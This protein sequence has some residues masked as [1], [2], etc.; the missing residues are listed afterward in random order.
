MPLP[1]TRAPHAPPPADRLSRRRHFLAATCLLVSGCLDAGSVALLNPN[2][3]PGAASPTTR[4]SAIPGNNG[5][6]QATPSSPLVVLHSRTTLR[7]DEFRDVDSFVS[8]IGLGPD[9]DLLWEF[10]PPNLIGVKREAGRADVIYGYQP[11][12]T[13]VTVRLRRD[14]TIQAQ[15]TIEVSD[16]HTTG[17]LVEPVDTGIHIGDVLNYRAVLPGTK[18]LYA[19]R[20]RWH[21]N[22][23]DVIAIDSDTGR[24]TALKPGSAIITSTSDDTRQN[25]NKRYMGV[26]DPKVVAP[27]P[28]PVATVAPPGPTRVM[29]GRW[30]IVSTIPASHLGSNA[31]PALDM[32]FGDPM[33]GYVVGGGGTVTRTADGGLTWQ[34]VPL[35][36]GNDDDPATAIAA[37]A[38]VSAQTG[39]VSTYGGAVWRTLDGGAHWLKS[40]VSAGKVLR[41]L[42]AK[43]SNVL[44]GGDTTVCSRSAD[45]GVT[46]Q[47]TPN[48]LSRGTYRVSMPG[49]DAW[50]VGPNGVA[51][52]TPGQGWSGAS[53]PHSLQIANPLAT[54]LT[55]VLPCIADFVSAETGFVGTMYD[56]YR[57]TDGAATWRSLKAG[58]TTSAYKTVVTAA[59]GSPPFLILAGSFC[60]AKHGVVILS[61]ALAMTDDGGETWSFAAVPTQDYPTKAVMIDPTH[62]WVVTRANVVWRYTL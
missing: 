6:A 62:A 25:P 58:L 9:R 5:P 19:R 57:T 15:M 28:S 22:A 21:S 34:A 44:V 13:D 38:F 43:D 30:T 61:G 53:V 20:V 14:P 1:P 39:W 10:S 16:E 50:A 33:T 45:G 17:Y 54:N 41:S 23:P 59:P 52:L 48:T 49:A 47:A 55:P 37:A 36:E 26:A 4:S 60:D 11:G 42:A 24:A 56:L 46:W 27:S 31:A 40:V 8:P 32:A 2:L 29:A 18:I 51:H 7:Q 12:I 3:R 35:P